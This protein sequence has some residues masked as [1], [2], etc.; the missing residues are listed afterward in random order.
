M[1]QNIPSDVEKAFA[2]FAVGPRQSLLKVRSLI[3]EAAK[4]HNTGAITETLKWG[5]PSYLTEASKSGSTIRLGL[6]NDHAAVFF[7]C[8]TTLV[9][10]FRSDFPDAFEYSGNRALLVDCQSDDAA[11]AICLGRALTYH[12]DKRKARA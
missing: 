7:N 9:D 5:Q 4:T 6:L 10:G 11:L 3:F 1:T 12:R 8:N 2:K